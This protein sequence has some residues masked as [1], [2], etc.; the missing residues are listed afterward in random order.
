[1]Q[2][3]NSIP[4][5]AKGRSPLS[6]TIIK[7]VFVHLF[8]SAVNLYV[9]NPPMQLG[10]GGGNIK[11]NIA[12]GGS[13]ININSKNSK[14]KSREISSGLDPS[15]LRSQVG[16]TAG[17]LSG[18]YI[19]ATIDEAAH[20]RALLT[21]V[22]K[23][24]FNMKPDAMKPL[25]VMRETMAGIRRRETEEMRHEFYLMSNKNTGDNDHGFMIKSEMLKL[26]LGEYSV[27]AK[28]GY[29]TYNREF[30]EQERDARNK[31]I[32]EGNGDPEVSFEVAEADATDKGRSDQTVDGQDAI[33]RLDGDEFER[34]QEARNELEISSGC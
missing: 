8:Y 6:T 23:H 4:F 26:R 32:T 2:I 24:V 30:D 5:T 25:S 19:S 15:N 3:A 16:Y 22:L 1:M 28:A 34:D 11:I 17:E 7:E 29:R 21:V 27:G 12:K 13:K 18:E 9:K 31:R 33:E 10:G 14:S 20:R